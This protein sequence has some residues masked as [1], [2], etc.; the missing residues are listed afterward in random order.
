MSAGIFLDK[1][2]MRFLTERGGIL[3]GRG[4]P[5]PPSRS[6]VPDYHPEKKG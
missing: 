4:E 6:V 2:E 3:G 1:R 5:W